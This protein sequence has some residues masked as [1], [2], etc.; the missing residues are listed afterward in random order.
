MIIYLLKV[1]LCSASLLL[2][3]RALLEKEKMF[4]FNRFYLLGSLVLSV[5]LPLIPLE[6][7]LEEPIFTPPPST[8]TDFS[9]GRPEP[10]T[11]SL[12]PQPATPESVQWFWLTG[13]MYLFITAWLLFRYGR[14]I[15]RL[16]SRI[17]T[18]E[19]RIQQGLNLVLLPTETMPHSY[20]K[21]VFLTKSDYLNGTVEQQVLDHEMAHV[22][23]F[24]SLDVL[25]VELVKVLFW[26]NP[27]FYYY[28]DAIALN[29][30]FLADEAV[31]GTCE[32]VPAYQHLLLRKVLGA[33][34]QPF[35]SKFNYS[36]TKKRF[37]MMNKHTSRRRA[38]LAQLSV[39]PLVV[40]AVFAFSDFSL[41]QV[42]PPPPP[43]PAPI[44][45]MSTTDLVKEYNELVER[46][47]EK[48][49]S[50]FTLVKNPSAADAERMEELMKAMNKEQLASLQ[51]VIWTFKPSPPN[52]PTETEYEKY[53]NPAVYGVWIDDKK[54][55]NS[56]L[57]K[58]K[59]KDFSKA[60]VS[61]LYLN[62]QKTI[63]YK[64]KY[65]LNLMTTAHYEAYRKEALANPRKYLVPNKGKIPE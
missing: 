3:Y 65:Q 18:H 14:N 45:Q 55:P 53:K 10:Y 27:A 41:A 15:Y 34:D 48:K 26:F 32:D 39:L 59:P 56:E 4:R 20:L 13:G 51:H 58:Y 37:V 24:H 64:Y 38:L 35:I 42:P 11:V 22:R 60:S 47:L 7:L 30:E 5:V 57:N 9:N 61:K 43:V 36:F 54:V 2:F 17:Q 25:L 49:E 31:L 19:V 52:V 16:R 1:L 21:Y 63:G 23:Q 46:Y 29:H 8:V 44:S 28:R 33:A 50:G 12:L 6:I 40:L 62:A